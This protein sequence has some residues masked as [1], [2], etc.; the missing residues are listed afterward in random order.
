MAM[1]PGHSVSHERETSSGQKIRDRGKKPKGK[2]DNE[3]IL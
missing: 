3:R 1:N 2:G